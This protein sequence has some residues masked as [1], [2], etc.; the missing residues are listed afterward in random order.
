MGIGNYLGSNIGQWAFQ[1][2][3]RGR[4][5]WDIVGR[6]ERQD[7][8]SGFSSTKSDIDVSPDFLMEIF[9]QM[10]GFPDVSLCCCKELRTA[11]FWSALLNARG[12]RVVGCIEDALK[13][14]ISQ[15]WIGLY[16]LFDVSTAFAFQ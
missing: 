5:Q 10:F 13:L 6:H 12:A 14:G 2:V 16:L 7:V 15:N 4:G 1:I 3:L 8:L 11:F 9:P